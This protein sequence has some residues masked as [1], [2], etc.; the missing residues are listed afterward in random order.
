MLMISDGTQGKK[1]LLT[2]GASIMMEHTIKQFAP[3]TY[4]KKN[5]LSITAG[6][7]T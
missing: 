6:N 7:K 4:M 2:T 3:G 5:T 1:F